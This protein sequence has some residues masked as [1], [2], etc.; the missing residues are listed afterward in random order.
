MGAHVLHVKQILGVRRIVGV[1]RDVRRQHHV[2][3]ILERI[4]NVGLGVV[5]V[6]RRAG[7]DAILQRRDER[8]GVDDRGA[9]R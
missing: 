4:G 9:R 8:L 2:V 3:E 1:A 5:D 6:D 7:D